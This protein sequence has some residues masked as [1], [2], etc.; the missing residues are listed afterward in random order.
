MRIYAG[1]LVA[2]L[3]ALQPLTAGPITYTE[4]GQLSGTLGTTVLTNTSFTFV[5]NGD[6]ANITG[7]NPL[8]NIALSNSL[9]L[10]SSIGSFTTAVEVGVNPLSGVIGFSNT[11]ENAGITFTSATAVGYGL[12][13]PIAITGGT[14]LFYT[15][16]FATSLGTLDITSAQNL[17]F[18]ASG[19]VPEPGTLAL[20]FIGLFGLLA[21]CFRSPRSG[22]RVRAAL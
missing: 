18:T 14:P 22:S 5:F 15:G 2:T 17:G 11:A 3:A 10:G 16:T 6:T 13:T 19:G 7:S 20:V 12:A 9:S 8:L 1:L 21:V 4:T